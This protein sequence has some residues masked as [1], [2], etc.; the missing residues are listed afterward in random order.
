MIEALFAT[1]QSWAGFD[2]V[3]GVNNRSLRQAQAPKDRQKIS[4]FE[5][6]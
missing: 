6:G 4:L 2:Q 5:T 1:Q 3:A